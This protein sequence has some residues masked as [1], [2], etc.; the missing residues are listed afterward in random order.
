MQQNF[1]ICLVQW[2]CLR[3][4]LAFSP[5]TLEENEPFCSRASANH[6]V[7]MKQQLVFCAVHSMTAS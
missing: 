7:V 6:V 1:L 3:K 2:F 5:V 4:V